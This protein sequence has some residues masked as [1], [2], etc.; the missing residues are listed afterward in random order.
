MMI[1]AHALSAGAILVT[2]NL[3]HF[4]RIALPLQIID[5]RDAKAGGA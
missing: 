2:H 4:A 1:A 3:R 5:W